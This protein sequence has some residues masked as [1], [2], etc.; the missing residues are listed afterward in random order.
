[1]TE[2]AVVFDCKIESSWE[3]LDCCIESSSV[4]IS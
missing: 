2:F 1:M 3:N 4:D